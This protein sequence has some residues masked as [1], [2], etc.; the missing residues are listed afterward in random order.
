MITRR[1]IL[2]M[3]SIGLVLPSTFGLSLQ[4]AVAQSTTLRVYFMPLSGAGTVDD[5][6]RPKYASTDLAGVP[7]VSMN[8]GA[9]PLCMVLAAVTSGQHSALAAEP[10]VITTPATLGNTIGGNLTAVQNALDAINIPSNWVQNTQTY[11]QVLRIVA[12]IFLFA[13]RLHRFTPTRLFDTGIALSTQFQDLPLGMRQAL[14]NAATELG[15]DTSGL[16]G[17]NTVRQM[18]K[19][20]GD[21]FSAA[22]PIHL[23]GQDL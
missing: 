12:T 19:A 14:Q 17:T 11:A 21:Q 5:K 15:Y 20:L 1:A 6:R 8:Y 10:D 18:L 16:S 4:D 3:A 7:F 23:G 2:Q 9:E 13:Q 22:L